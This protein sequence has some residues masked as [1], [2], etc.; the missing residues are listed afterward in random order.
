ME[1]LNI[2]GID[3]YDYDNGGLSKK[4]LYDKYGELEVI[5]EFV[6]PKSGFSGYALQDPSMEIVIA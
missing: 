6:G 4:D 1:K 2:A 5:D 3:I